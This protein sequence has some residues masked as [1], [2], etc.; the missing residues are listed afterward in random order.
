MIDLE[1]I[2]E[3]LLKADKIDSKT[4]KLVEE[5]FE[6]IKNEEPLLKWVHILQCE[7]N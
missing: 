1:T 4:K 3:E 7:D 2:Y 6:K 5:F